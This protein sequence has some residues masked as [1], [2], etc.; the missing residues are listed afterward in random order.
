MI[1]QNGDSGDKE[2]I[3]MADH[4]QPKIGM[5]LKG[6]VKLHQKLTMTPCVRKQMSK[7]EAEIRLLLPPKRKFE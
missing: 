5:E 4:S 2:V 7:E 3:A 6:M 1:S